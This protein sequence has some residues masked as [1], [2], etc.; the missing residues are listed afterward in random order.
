MTLRKLW[1]RLQEPEGEVTGGG[2]PAPSPAPA[3]SSAPSAASSASGSEAPASDA[4][5]DAFDFGALVDYNGGS[6][7]PETPPA[8][9][10]AQ[11]AA[12]APT[13]APPASAAPAPVAS[14]ATPQPSPT[15][16]PAAPQAPATAQP[17]ASP[18]QP[19]Q[20][21][22]PEKHRAEFIPKLEQLYA[23]SDQE[24]SDFQTNP[25]ASLSR[26]AAQLHYNMSLSLQTAIRQFL[27]H[28]VQNE[29][30]V[31]TER[32]KYETAFYDKWPPLKEAVSKDKVKVEATI[33]EAIQAYRITNPKASIEDVIQKAGVLAML[34]LGIAPTMQS[35]PNAPA[36]GP[37]APFIS[38]GRPAGAGM[39]GH[40]P[41]RSAPG[42]QGE[43]DLYG[44]IYDHFQGGGG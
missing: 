30:T 32:Q 19:A 38:P 20:P 41:P 7:P 25:G 43:E 44:G 42:Q 29:L 15:E 5:G 9:P 2:A 10:V 16:Q 39:Q 6:E 12:P 31:T 33:N 34:S 26:L 36:P 35:T 11:P 14:P 3:E 8:A 17:S 4:G 22:D 28:V 24:V 37:A 23:L 27:P 13:P 40:V 21:F 1:T 18:E